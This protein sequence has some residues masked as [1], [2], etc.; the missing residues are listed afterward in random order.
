MAAIVGAIFL[1][2]STIVVT[3]A[4]ETTYGQWIAARWHWI[5]PFKH[6]GKAALSFLFGALLW[7]PLNQLGEHRCFSRLSDNSAVDRAIDRKRDPLE[8]LLRQAL[9]SRQTIAVTLKSGKVY[10]G[11]LTTN[12][13]PAFAIESIHL[14][15]RRSGHRGPNTQKLTVDVDYDETHKEVRE[16]IENEFR[17]R[18]AEAYEKNSDAS[19]EE[20]I[21]LARQQISDYGDIQNYEIVILM[22]EVVSVNFFDLELY[23]K[24]FSNK[25]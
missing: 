2:L 16:V 3:A 10:I 19:D 20:L 4:Y 23:D 5:V 25:L 11:I 21:D 13:N 7:R 15:L 22:S 9:G 14:L 8:L 6:S 24:H 1:L 12:L 18:L 17:Q